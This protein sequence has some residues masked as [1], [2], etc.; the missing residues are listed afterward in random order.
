MRAH[1]LKDLITCLEGIDQDLVKGAVAGEKFQELVFAHAKD[2]KIIEYV[3][4]LLA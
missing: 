2:E 3:K 1:T 4:N